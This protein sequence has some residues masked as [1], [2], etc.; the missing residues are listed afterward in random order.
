M[1][2]KSI[3]KVAHYFDKAMVAV[4]KLT[5][6]LST[7]DSIKVKKGET[8]F[9]DVVGSMQIDKEPVSS[10]KAGMEVAVKISQAAREGAEVFKV[11]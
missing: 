8:E 4:V 2:E 10:A 9:T 5:G 7:G 6:N 11:E 3:G 1:A